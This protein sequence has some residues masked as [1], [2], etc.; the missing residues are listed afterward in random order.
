MK[1]HLLVLLVTLSLCVYVSSL[2]YSHP[3]VIKNSL[4]ICSFP[5]YMKP[6]TK[7]K[8]IRKNPT[9][10]KQVEIQ[11]EVALPGIDS[12]TDTTT[13]EESSISSSKKGTQP[14][15]SRRMRLDD[16]MSGGS[17]STIKPP[18]KIHDQKR[19]P[20]DHNKCHSTNTRWWL[21]P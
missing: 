7:N 15:R 4:K 10:S 6:V 2:C 1:P 17:A 13:V 14:L 5:L 19:N 21:V 8:N 3:N 9:V 11:V 20:V 12:S 18:E 16:Q